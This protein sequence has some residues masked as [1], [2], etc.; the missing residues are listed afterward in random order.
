MRPRLKL[1][2]LQRSSRAL[3]AANA[4]VAAFSVTPAAVAAAAAAAVTT[5]CQ[6]E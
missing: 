2:R 5:T 6:L 3:A 4:K 1:C